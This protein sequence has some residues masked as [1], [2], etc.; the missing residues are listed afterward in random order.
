MGI[1]AEV[2]EI[3]IRDHDDARRAEFLGSPTVRIDGRD[4]DPGA[5]GRTD[6]GF[7]CRRY[8]TSGV[9][10]RDLIEVAFSGH[11]TV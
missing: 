4:I 7:G 5:R 6:Y 9:P 10:P 1:D 11:A 2:E 8:G 3:E